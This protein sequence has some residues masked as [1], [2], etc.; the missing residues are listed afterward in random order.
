MSHR[1]QYHPSATHTERL[2]AARAAF[3]LLCEKREY[4]EMGA[5]LRPTSSSSPTHGG[6]QLD[7]WSALGLPA[8]VDPGLDDRRGSRGGGIVLD[9]GAIAVWS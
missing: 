8:A 5:R 7:F 9:A 1:R 2:L 3:E 6:E 4:G